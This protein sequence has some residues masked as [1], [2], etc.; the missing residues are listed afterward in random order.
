VQRVSINV[1]PGE[2]LAALKA[3]RRALG[4]LSTNASP[5][6]ALEVMFLDYPGLHRA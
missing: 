3:T 4:L 6:L 2:A 1:T 5:R